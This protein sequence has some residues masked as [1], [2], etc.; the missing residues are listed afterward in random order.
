MEGGK[1][2]HLSVEPELEPLLN[3]KIK[4]QKKKKGKTKVLSKHTL[5]QQQIIK[6]Q[7]NYNN[8]RRKKM[9]SAL[10]CFLMKVSIKPFLI[11]LFFFL[12][13]C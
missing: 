5:N 8:C 4:H 7:Y 9:T 3:Q 13:N 12:M 10:A 2:K 11:N 6:I 1:E